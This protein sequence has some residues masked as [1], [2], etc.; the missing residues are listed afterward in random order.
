M[1]ATV[2]ELEQST[3]YPLQP[4]CSFR[5]RLWL[6]ELCVQQNELPRLYWDGK[7]FVG[8]SARFSIQPPVERICVNSCTP[9]RPSN[10]Q[11][12]VFWMPCWDFP[13]IPMLTRT[14]KG[15]ISTSLR[16]LDFLHDTNATCERKRKK[17]VVILK[18]VVCSRT[19]TQTLWFNLSLRIFSYTSCLSWFA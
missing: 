14:A 7:A 8:I 10:L 13:S 15:R 6:G 4:C 12:T 11:T 16:V 1:F 5:R 19:K 18:K 2:R 9:T 3:V 17:S